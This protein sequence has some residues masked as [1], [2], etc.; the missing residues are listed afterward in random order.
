[1]VV[2]LERSLQRCRNRAAL[3]SNDPGHRHP[4][5]HLRSIGDDVVAH[6]ERAREGER[7]RL[8]RQVRRAH[9]APGETTKT[10]TIVVNGDS[11]QEADETFYLDLFGN[12]S[13]SLF[14]KSRGIGTIVN[15]D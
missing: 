3:R 7:Q 2:V 13:N 11:K 1:M 8:R 4:L 6:R 9:F 5:G 10:I 14:T 12:S 15:D